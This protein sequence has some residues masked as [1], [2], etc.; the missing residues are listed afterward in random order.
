MNMGHHVLPS[1]T[2]V[3][4]ELDRYV[5]AEYRETNS[6]WLTASTGRCAGVGRIGGGVKSEAP[7]LDAA[8]ATSK[9][10]CC[11]VTGAI[12]GS[13]PVNRLSRRGGPTGDR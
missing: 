9:V 5:R 3:R 11:P 7:P 2:R 1:A 4:P 6:C 10:R 13:G 12:P 8:V